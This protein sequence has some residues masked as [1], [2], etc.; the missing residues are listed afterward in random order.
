[1]AK[2]IIDDKE[3]GI[4]AFVVQLRSV[5]DHTLLKGDG[6]TEKCYINY[7]TFLYYFY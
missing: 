4:H 5:K 3:H 6:L 7:I 2:L 1:M